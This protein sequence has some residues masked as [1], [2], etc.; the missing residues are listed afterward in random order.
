MTE[1][2]DITK[3]QVAE[4]I[5]RWNHPIPE[6]VEN[7]PQSTWI[8]IRKFLSA[9]ACHLCLMKILIPT[10]LITLVFAGGAFLVWYVW[11]R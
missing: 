1:I 6:E 5:S 10:I 2:P 7:I 3:R 9:Q 11:L 8:K 4:M